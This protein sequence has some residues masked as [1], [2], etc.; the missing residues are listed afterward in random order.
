MNHKLFENWILN[1][2]DLTEN[3]S[4]ELQEHLKICP[5]CRH[6]ENGWQ[7]SKNLMYQST[8][9]TPAPGF[10]TRWLILAEKKHQI[11][12]VRRYRLTI[13]SL[14]LITFAASLV[15][16]IAS[17][18]FFHMLANGFTSLSRLIFSITDGLSLLGYWLG[19]MPIAIPLSIGFFFLGLV[20]A[21]M[22]AG[23]FTLWN[24]KQRKL[25]INEIQTD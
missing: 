3:Q 21:F 18:S 17:G 24:L 10:K 16:M 25:Q 8:P 1:E 19:R 15:Y 13:F 2:T 4:E 14:V 6:I 23:I 20:N 11:K 5:A 9:K 22:M 12:K 7:A